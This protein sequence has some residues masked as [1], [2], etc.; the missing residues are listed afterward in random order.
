M[1]MRISNAVRFSGLFVVSL[2]LSAGALA[3]KLTPL[4]HP[5]GQPGAPHA[6]ALAAPATSIGSTSASP[7]TPLTNQPA[8]LADGASYPILLQDGTVLV[9][10]AGFPDWWKL[11]PDQYGSY[12]NGTWTQVASLPYLPWLG[13]VYAPLYHSAAVLPDGRL[14]VMGG[15]YQC[16]PATFVC[17][18]VWE[19]GGAIYDPLADVWTPVSP[20]AGWTTI[21]D[22]QSVVLD[23]GTYMQ[24]NCCTFQSALLDA[25]TLTWRPTG[26]GK[27]DPNDEEGWNLLPGG[28]VLVV[29]AYVPLDGFPYMPDGTNSE[30]Y[31][32]RTGTWSSAGSTI[33]QLWDSAADCGG[34][35]VASFELGPAVLRPDGTVF[36]MGSNSCGG[37]N[38]AI[39]NSYTHT[40]R[41]GP[42]FPDDL[43]IADGPAALEPNG[44]VLMMASP[45]IYLTPSTFLEWDGRRLT[46]VPGTPNAPND[47]SYYGNMLV[48]PTGQILL[49][50]FSD[51]IEI[52]TPSPTP[53]Q[54][55][56]QEAPIVFL[57]PPVVSPGGS[58]LIL[59]VGFNGVSQGAFYGDDVQAA[60]N[61]PIVRITNLHTG[62]VFY[63][64]THDPSSMAV[65]SPNLVWATI[66]VNAAQ[67]RGPSKLEVTANGVA[68]E[69]VFVEVD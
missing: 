31:N 33:V 29:D 43:D 13:M 12:V 30:L 45:G 22:A 66:E 15:E 48:L 56:H 28:E 52:Y 37:A 2:V 40:W 9:Q 65:A 16:V 14:M 62:H 5:V 24:A 55:Q 58:Y 21:G 51:D 39:F 27:Y 10:D 57:A 8:F 69:P 11:T 35:A 25:R 26:A 50:D 53:P 34:E 18:P 44:K 17:N 23:N 61:Y 3:Q 60:T 20:P 64:R 41:P 59:G 7:W 4:P 67:E 19:T 32:P 42:V 49:T 6:A 63:A 38:T 36:Y 1:N 68:S 47:S 46:I 54:L